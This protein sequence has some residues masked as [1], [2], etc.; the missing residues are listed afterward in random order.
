LQNSV[1]K[2]ISDAQNTIVSSVKKVEDTVSAFSALLYVILA[3][4]IINLILTGIALMR[5]RPAK[6]AT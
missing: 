2:L 5:T 1:S 4:L 6:P 3:L